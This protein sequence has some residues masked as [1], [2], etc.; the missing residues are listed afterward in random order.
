MSEKKMETPRRLINTIVEIR[1]AE[2]G[3]DANEMHIVGKA[4]AFDSVETYYGESEVIDKKA[5]DECDM[6]DVVLRYNHSDQVPSLARTRNK[7][8]KLEIKEDGLYIDARLLDTTDGVDFYKRVKSGLI[9]KMSFA[10]TIDEDD[11]DAKNHLRTIKKIGKM[12]DVALVDFPFYKDTMVEAKQLDNRID[13]LPTAKKLQELEYKKQIQEI[14]HEIK[15]K[16]LLK[17]IG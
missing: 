11:Y 3:E 8:L 4:V 9:D 14:L 16:E 10:F 5:L 2:E 12:F 6:S 13:F 1:K 17:Q 15:R 7:S